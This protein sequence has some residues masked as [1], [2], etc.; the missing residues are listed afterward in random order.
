[1]EEESSIYGAGVLGPCNRGSSGEALY[2][3]GRAAKPDG[4]NSMFSITVKNKVLEPTCPILILGAFVCR[5]R[6]ASI[7]LKVAGQILLI[8]RAR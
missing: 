7:K 6:R 4:Y 3:I 2:P 1:M 8:L 5:V